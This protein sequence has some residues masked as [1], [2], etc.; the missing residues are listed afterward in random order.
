[1]LGSFLSVLALAGAFWLYQLQGRLQEQ[2]DSLKVL[3]RSVDQ[4]SGSQRLAV[5]TLL[6]KLGTETAGQFVERYERAAKARDEARR[7]LAAQQSINEALGL[8]TK[9]LEDS[10]QAGH[11]SRSGQDDAQSVRDRCQARAQAA[12]ENQRA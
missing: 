12:G 8:R 6:E 1:M 5:D 3:A 11:G 9:E 7:Q 2:G 10:R 4:V